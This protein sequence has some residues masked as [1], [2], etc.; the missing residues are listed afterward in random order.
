MEQGKKHVIP[1]K[2]HL[3]VNQG[4][5]VMSLSDKMFNPLPHALPIEKTT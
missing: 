3:E 2:G 4:D 5:L 1:Y